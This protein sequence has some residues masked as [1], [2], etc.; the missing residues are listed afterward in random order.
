MSSQEF[1]PL[2]ASL[3]R[4]LCLGD[5]NQMV[6]AKVVARDVGFA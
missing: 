1:Q 2:V 6:I 3:Q 5:V 4:R